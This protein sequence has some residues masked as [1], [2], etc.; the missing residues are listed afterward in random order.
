MGSGRMAREWV[1]EEG[2]RVVR[3]EG[4][5]VGQLGRKIGEEWGWKH[6]VEMDI[7]LPCMM[8]TDAGVTIMLL[9]NCSLVAN[10]HKE[11]AAWEY[12][13][14]QPQIQWNVVFTTSCDNA[15]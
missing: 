9:D 3:E 2:E 12:I 5:I 10:V 8:M 1:G 13:Q 4:E 7:S 6:K 11:M 15:N 14:R